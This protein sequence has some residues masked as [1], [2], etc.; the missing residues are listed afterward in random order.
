MQVSKMQIYIAHD[1]T[2]AS[3]LCSY[4]SFCYCCQS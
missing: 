1:V 3:K 2:K 4:V